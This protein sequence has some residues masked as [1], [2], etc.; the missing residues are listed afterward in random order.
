TERAQQ[1]IDGIRNGQSLEVLLGVQFERGLHDWTTRPVQP[2]ILDQLKPLF[3]TKFPILKTRVPQAKNASEGA[4]AAQIAEDDQVTNG[5]TL[6]ETTDA[7][8]YGIP[9]LSALTQAQVD[10][11]RLEKDRIADTLDAL[12]DLLTAESA[13]Q[14]ALGNF[15]RAAGVLQAMGAGTV[16]PD[17]EVLDTPR[18]TSLS[19]TQRLAVQF[20][21]SAVNNPWPAIALTERAKLEPSLNAWLGDLLGAPD[22]ILCSASAIAADGTVLVS[23]GAPVQDTV[24]LADLG[25]QP[26]DFVFIARNQVEASGA[27][28]LEQ[29]VRFAFARHKN[30]ADDVVVR[31]AFAD[32]G[33]GGANARSFAEMLPLADRLRRLVG[34]TRVLDGRH[35]QSASKDTQPAS[36]NPGRID[37]GEL[38][39]RVG[40][41]IAAVRALFAPLQ[42]ARDAAQA[43]ATAANLDAVRSQ[44]IDI[45]NAGVS[46]AF[47]QSSAG[48]GDAQLASL[49]QQADAILARGAAL[50]TATDDELAQIDAMTGAEKKAS[51]LG[52]VAKV[53]M[54]SDFVVLPR[55]AFPNADAVAQSDAARDAL[56][57]YVRDTVGEPLAVDEWLHGAACVRASVHDF[58]MVRVMAEA[59]RADPLA[60]SPIQLP[61]RTNDNWLAATYPSDTQIVHDTI[62]IVRHLP[63]GFDARAPQCGLLIDEWIESIPERD[64]VTGLAFNFNAPNSA[65][66]QA[67]LLAV[68]P[69]ETGRWQ[70]DHLVNSITDTF[71][72]ARLRAVEPDAL[73]TIPALGT[74]LPAVI[75]EFSTSRASVSLDYAMAVP[76]VSAAVNATLSVAA[77]PG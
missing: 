32:A 62:S 13:Y 45:A 56:V 66:P 47:P 22:T 37:A 52:D 1:L 54:G 6:A 46:Y 48:A 10:A 68:T 38:R 72:R 27:A 7:Y 77:N 30:V 40:A 36:D 35:F 23:G 2:V 64:T 8:P 55:F 74:L 9:E 75:A 58:E 57:A 44:L 29:R 31:I 71:R 5:L 65:A 26:I 15:D 67:V 73:G 28:E 33:G 24:S 41:R 3:R 12:R 69:D 11:I 16:P 61:F 60:L 20:T 63:Q 19:F 14:L 4:G 49:S 50:G 21:T 34:K 59:W 51:M 70:W 53:W 76:F 43:N 18:A 42:A 17:I 25:V 39:A